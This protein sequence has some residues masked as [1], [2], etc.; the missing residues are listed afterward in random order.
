[1]RTA[2]VV[3]L[4]VVFCVAAAAEDQYVNSV[5]LTGRINT[6]QF[7]TLDGQNNLYFFFI[8]DTPR[9]R[10]LSFYCVAKG[11]IAKD[12]IAL[13]ETLAPPARPQTRINLLI[14]GYLHN[15]SFR[16]FPITKANQPTHGTCIRVEAFE[17]IVNDSK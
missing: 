7:P 16:Y 10:S 9:M 11:R 6:Y 12:I 15:R 1:M 14:R 4:L 13:L 2:T 8:V 17:V 3:L 5:S